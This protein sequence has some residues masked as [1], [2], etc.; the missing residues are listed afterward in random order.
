VAALETNLTSGRDAV[1]RV[2]PPFSARMRARLHVLQD[3]EASGDPGPVSVDPESLLTDDA[4]SYP[5][6]AETEETL[7]ADPGREYTVETHRECHVQA[8]ESWRS[9]VT[10]TVRERTSI[11]VRDEEIPVDVYVL[12]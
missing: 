7:R 6:P 5:R 8:V 11:V 10:E 3:S 1:L 9:A 12:G 2:T 4:P